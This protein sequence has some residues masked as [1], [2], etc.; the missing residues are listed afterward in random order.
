MTF[1]TLAHAFIFVLMVVSVFR[2][3]W[4]WSFGR[5]RVWSEEGTPLP[6]ATYWASLACDT[7]LATAAAWI[8]LS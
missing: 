4:K 3:A 8:L 2:V 6:F 1:A 5:G 7:S